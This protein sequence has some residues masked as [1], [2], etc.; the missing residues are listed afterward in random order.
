M[1]DQSEC[2]DHLYIPILNYKIKT[3]IHI[4]NPKPYN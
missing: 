4:L 3:L 2:G 1:D